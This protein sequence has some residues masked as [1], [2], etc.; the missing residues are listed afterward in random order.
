M[1][2]LEQIA[3]KMFDYVYLMF[4]LL[5]PFII[6]LFILFLFIN[7]YIFGRQLLF[8]ITKIPFN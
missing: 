8:L 2:K 1:K 3:D 7:L 4:K 5:F 6:T